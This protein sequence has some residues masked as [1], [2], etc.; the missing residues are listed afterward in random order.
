MKFKKNY[1]LNFGQEIKTNFI[2]DIQEEKYLFIKYKFIKS[3][4]DVIHRLENTILDLEREMDTLIITHQAV[5]R[6]IIAY[7]CDIP[8]DMVPY[9][10]IPI[11]TLFVITPASYGSKTLIYTFDINNPTTPY[12]I[13]ENEIKIIREHKGSH[14]ECGS[15][16]KL[17]HGSASASG[18]YCSQSS[19]E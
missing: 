18:G 6:C 9:I 1:L 19:A 17:T 15:T 13:K 12:E 11:H 3:Y 10:D 8:S 14:S 5:A 16:H 2:I 4:V 7:F